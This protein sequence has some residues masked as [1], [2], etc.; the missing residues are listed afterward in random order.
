MR[1]KISERIE[2]RGREKR[3]RGEERSGI[4]EIEEEGKV[5]E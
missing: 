3:N 5:V 2:G 4:V 1:R